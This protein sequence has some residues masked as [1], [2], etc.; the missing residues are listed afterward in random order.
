MFRQGA[1]LPFICKLFKDQWMAR[2]AF[3]SW[4]LPLNFINGEQNPLCLE[5]WNKFHEAGVDFTEESGGEVTVRIGGPWAGPCDGRRGWWKPS[6]IRARLPQRRHWAAG[7]SGG[8]GSRQCALPLARSFLGHTSPL[9]PGSWQLARA[10]SWAIPLVF[11]FWR[12][13]K[14]FSSHQFLTVLYRHPA[15][16]I[17]KSA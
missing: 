4:P 16:G 7:W 6:V 14:T 1:S 2:W 3:N 17:L 12:H 9:S 11:N 10:L 15:P 5:Q 8:V 13:R